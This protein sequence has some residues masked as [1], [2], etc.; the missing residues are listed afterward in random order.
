M[1]GTPALPPVE[2]KPG[3]LVHP[4]SDRRLAVEHW[5]LATEP[6]T[7]HD[8]IRV[9]W[10][11][12]QVALLPLGGLFSAVRIPGRLIYAVTGTDGNDRVDAFLEHVLQGGPV[13]CDAYG[14]RFYALVP[15][16]MPVT[17]H[18]AADEWRAESEV[19]VLGRGTYLGVPNVDAVEFD[20]AACSYWSVP[21]Q[22]PGELCAPLAVARL[23]AA[24]V[25]ALAAQEPLGEA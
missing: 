5:L 19:D 13:I 3:V 18:Q 15:A 21:M 23:I 4:A 20:P 10:Q 1:T 8:R 25:H 11:E 2:P 16:G 22:S 6:A 24:G 12:N 9:E 7:S 14:H 17:W